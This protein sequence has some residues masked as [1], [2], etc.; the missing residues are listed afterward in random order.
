M[1]RHPVET[2]IRRKVTERFR[3]LPPTEANVR[4]SI[5]YARQLVQEAIIL[6]KLLPGSDVVGSMGV[7]A[8]PGPIAP[9]KLIVVDKS[10]RIKK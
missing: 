9:L 10:G 4:A 2:E 6:G 5:D 3:L 1:K 8:P 7:K